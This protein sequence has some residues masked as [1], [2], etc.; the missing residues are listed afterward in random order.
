[1]A[2]GLNPVLVFYEHS[3]ATR[4]SISAS[5]HQNNESGSNFADV[6]QVP[7]TDSFTVCAVCYRPRPGERSVPFQ[8]VGFAPVEAHPRFD[9]DFDAPGSELKAGA[10]R[11]RWPHRV[12]RRSPPQADGL[13]DTRRRMSRLHPDVRRGHGD[14]RE[15]EADQKPASKPK[16]PKAQERYYQRL[17]NDEIFSIHVAL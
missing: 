1:M 6:P 5:G 15:A 3:T 12:E 7:V 8:D 4:G 9:L 14:A 11:P 2:A 10:E 13:P 16:K 17:L